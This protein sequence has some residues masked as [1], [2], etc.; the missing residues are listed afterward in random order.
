[1]TKRSGRRPRS[2][3]PASTTVGL[4]DRPSGATRE[5]TWRVSRALNLFGV[6]LRPFITLVVRGGADID[7]D[8][9]VVT[10]ISRHPRL[11][12]T[13]IGHATSRTAAYPSR[14]RSTAAAQAIVA[15]AAELDGARVAPGPAHCP[16]PNRA[17]RCKAAGW[18]LGGRSHR[19][20]TRAPGGIGP[21]Q[22]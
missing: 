7:L 10:A 4:P 8:E 22:T 5:A 2:T 15:A 3:F 9:F 6:G 13:D 18:V 17:Y 16:A 1:M 12:I 11:V 20:S 21:H 19:C 14:I